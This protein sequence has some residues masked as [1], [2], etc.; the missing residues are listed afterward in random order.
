[1]TDQ[2]D[3]TI[4]ATP[5][6][7]AAAP[8]P[9]AGV[10]NRGRWIVALGATAM[11]VVGIVAIA[12]GA[13]K[14]GTASVTPRYLPATTIAFID[15]RL[16]L[17]GDQRE[18]VSALLS[19]FPGFAD[20]ANLDLKLNDFFERVV[21]G[22]SSGRY[23]YAADVQPWFGGRVAIGLTGMP[24]AGTTS[25]PAPVLMLVSVSDAVKARV[26][27]ERLLKDATDA[28]AKVTTETIDGATLW[29]LED[30]S[31]RTPGAA[32]G[33][34]ALTTDMIVIGTDRGLVAASV[35]L[36]RGS[37]VSLGGSAAFEAAVGGLPEARLGTLYIDGT[38]IR[39]A[40]AALA[41][42][43]PG[44][45]TALAA[46]P[47]RIA[48]S[49]RVADGAVTFEL[50]A[51]A[52]T[53]SALLSGGSST[54]ADRVPGDSVA[55]A[56]VSNLGAAIGEA[57]KAVKPQ[58]GSAVDPEQLKGIETVLGAPLESYFDWVGDAALVVRV[59]G[60]SPGGALVAIVKDAAVAQARL[61]QLVTVIKL[62]TLDPSSGVH[63]AE[64]TGSGTTIT[65]LTI[66]QGGIPKIGWALKGDLFVLGVGDGS[67]AWVLDTTPQTALSASPAYTAA[68]KAAGSSAGHGVVY[69][70]VAGLL[71]VFESAYT[72]ADARAQ[73]ERDIKPWLEPVS[74]F[75]A[76]SQVDGDSLV[77]R[78]SLTTT[79]P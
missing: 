67:V 10:S 22:A 58:L 32:D 2:I 27:L 50:R 69:L 55:F 17:P 7:V 30:P 3:P 18:Q 70:D 44:L 26:A 40:L 25:G 73:Y 48:G 56:G 39:T 4:A 65:E 54:I 41:A 14:S 71:A 9:A 11:V 76:T 34:V 53:G 5:E 12:L 1:M 28:G 52:P 37:G 51:S 60:A 62:A 66:D 74:A 63:V 23:S 6:A 64:V 20:Q 35:A 46:L 43:Q 16:D 77:L 21:K 57:V 42:S 24:A 72:D 19:R 13:G 47:E 8:K 15:A 59:S 61:G 79:K 36:S 29:L 49:L 45:D 38:A 75:I 33:V 31:A 78:A 68:L